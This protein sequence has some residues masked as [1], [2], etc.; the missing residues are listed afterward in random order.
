M[1]IE[2]TEEGDDDVDHRHQSKRSAIKR[3]GTPGEWKHSTRSYVSEWKRDWDIYWTCACLRNSGWLVCAVNAVY[4]TIAWLHTLARC[5]CDWRRKPKQCAQ[6]SSC[7]SSTI[8]SGK[9]RGKELI[10]HTVCD[11]CDTLRSHVYIWLLFFVCRSMRCVRM[12]LWH[13]TD[14]FTSHIIYNICMLV[15]YEPNV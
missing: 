7:R 5:D 8:P 4:R 3:K 6:D 12:Y 13:T 1:K 9:E 2:R 14:R 15:N 10:E 11:A